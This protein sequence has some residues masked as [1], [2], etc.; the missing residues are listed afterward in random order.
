MPE[1]VHEFTYHGD[2]D[3]T[4]RRGILQPTLTTPAM[5]GWNRHRYG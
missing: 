1:L 2:L 5:A 4:S 3:V